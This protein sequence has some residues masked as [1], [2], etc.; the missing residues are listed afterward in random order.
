M[1]PDLTWWN[2]PFGLACLL[3]GAG[4][5]ALLAV[6]RAPAVTALAHAAMGLGMAAMFLPALDPVPHAAWVALFVVSGAWFGAE[7]LRAGTVGGPAGALVVGAAAMLFMLLVGHDHAATSAG[8]V[9]PEH[10]HHAASGGSGALLVTVL[11]LVF[12]AWYATDLVRHATHRSADV[13]AADVPAA[14]V[15]AAG[16]PVAVVERAAVRVSPQVVA[17]V[18][19]SVAM[20]VMLL[21]MA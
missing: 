3:A 4:Y 1:G 6:R 2:V 12:A 7:A 5:L 11:A 17:H 9:D 8:P 19:M 15:P 16:A 10:A 21:G 14:D 13:P 20:L 18:V